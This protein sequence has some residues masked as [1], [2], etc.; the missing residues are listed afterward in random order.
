MAERDVVE[1]KISGTKELEDA[2]ERL[3]RD[4]ARKIVKKSLASSAR[5]W[6]DEMKR[7][8]QQ[9][10][11][12][13]SFTKVTKADAGKRGGAGTYGGREQEFGV[14]S[15]SIS[16]RVKLD[17]DELGGVAQVGPPKKAFWALWLE[18]GRK[19]QRKYPFIRPSFDA[20]KDEV[21]A[22]YADSIRAEL[23][24]SMG[25]K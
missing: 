21:L 24:S 13:F 5:L 12:V 1:C 19:G 25:L 22:K 23:K 17:P 18:F 14:V 3:P 6:L 11:H 15:R 10:W 7:T 4:V 2:L 16:L 8:V 9:G 20:K